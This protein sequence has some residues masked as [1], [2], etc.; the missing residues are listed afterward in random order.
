MSEELAAAAANTARLRSEATAADRRTAADRASAL[1]NARSMTPAKRHHL[2]RVV[3]VIDRFVLVDAVQVPEPGFP[4]PGQMVWSGEWW[5]IGHYE[6]V[7]DPGKPW[8]LLRR[9]VERRRSCGHGN[10]A[11]WVVTKGGAS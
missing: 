3:E 1:A 6:W 7:V 4:R 11:G 9:W 10:G 5:A 8:G 2:V